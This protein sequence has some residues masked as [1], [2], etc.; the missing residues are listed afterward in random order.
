MEIIR[1]VGSPRLGLLFDVYHVQIMDGDLI[2]RIHACREAINHVHTAGNPGRGELDERQEINYLP[3]M[4]ALVDIGYRG[5]VGHEF[6][7]T[8]DALAGLRQA[9]RT[10]DA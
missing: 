4:Q 10:C 9:V 1:Q 5:Y 6:I 2:T 7:P 3:V 8:R